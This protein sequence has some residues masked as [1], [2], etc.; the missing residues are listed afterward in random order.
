[1]TVKIEFVW[2]HPLR[3][4]NQAMKNPPTSLWKFGLALAVE[5]YPQ[6]HLSHNR[7]PPTAKKTDCGSEPAMT[8]KIEFVWLHLLRHTNQARKNPPTSLRKFGLALAVENYPQSHLYQNRMPPT[9]KKKQ[10]AGQSP[11]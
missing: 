7:M 1:M 10:I 4:T 2:W 11:Q 8:V 6:S 3:H 9:E 5:N